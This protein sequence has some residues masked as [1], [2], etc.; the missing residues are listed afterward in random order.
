MTRTKLVESLRYFLPTSPAR[1]PHEAFSSSASKASKPLTNTAFVSSSDGMNFCVLLSEALPSGSSPELSRGYHEVGAQLLKAAGL[2]SA[3]VRNAA[4]GPGAIFGR[5]LWRQTVEHVPLWSPT[6]VSEETVSNE[7]P[8][9]PLIE[10]VGEAF[11]KF[12]M[13]VVPEAESE[14]SQRLWSTISAQW[15]KPHELE[16]GSF[17]FNLLLA[18]WVVDKPKAAISPAFGLFSA[19]DGPPPLK[20]S[21]AFGSWGYYEATQGTRQQIDGLFARNPVDPVADGG[22]FLNS[23]FPG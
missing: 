9:R 17:A 14:L 2:V 23:S 11:A 22:N 4:Q 15:P 6:T 8:M 1:A 5:E 7:A 19:I 3:H 12:L 10:R 20:T 21:I 18:V 13:I 16:E